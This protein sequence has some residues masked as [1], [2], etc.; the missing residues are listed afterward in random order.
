MVDVDEEPP[1]EGRH[2]RYSKESSLLQ[3]VQD[4]YREAVGSYLLKEATG[5]SPRLLDRSKK[6]WHSA[7]RTCR[8]G[9]G[10]MAGLQHLT[11]FV[12]E[13]GAGGILS[14]RPPHQESVD[15]ESR[16]TDRV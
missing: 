13:R 4:H 12:T 15:T 2:R 6:I 3:G 1:E 8:V 7:D 14:G 11:P 9:L 10:L 16:R 5:H